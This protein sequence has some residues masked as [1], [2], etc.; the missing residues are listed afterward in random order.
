MTRKEHEKRKK[1]NI[2][3]AK[4][5]LRGAEATLDELR[6]LAKEL[7]E[8]T[9]F[10]YAWKIIARA[11]RR[12]EVERDRDLNL[13]LAQQQAVSTY[14]DP[15]LPADQKLDRAFEILEK[16]DNLRATTNQETL[17][18]AGAIYK[19][20][21]EL[22][23]HK[24]HLERSLAFYLRGHAQGVETGDNGYTGI[25]A[26][27]ILDLLAEQEEKDAAEAYTVSE[28]APKRRAE[29][30]HIREEI[31]DKLTKKAAQPGNDWLLQ[32]WWFL[33]T[34]AEAHFGMRHYDEARVW[35]R[36]AAALADVADWERESTVRQLVRLA[37]LRQKNGSDV[38]GKA[39]E[40]PAWDTLREFLKL[41]YQELPSAAVEAALKTAFRG[42]VGLALSGGGFRASLYHIGVLARLAELDVLRHVEVL[43]CVSGGSIIG[44][45]YYLEVRNLLQTVQEGDIK[46]EHYIKI[47]QKIEK[48]FL[49]GVQTNIRTRV[50][51]E[52][53]TNVK[54][55]FF[56]NYSRTMRVGELYEKQ[57]YSRIKD[58]PDKEKNEPR[59]LNELTVQPLGD[60]DF[61]PKYDNWRRWAK[62]PILV[63]NAT[64][65]NTGHN[66][67]FTATWM[68]EPPSAIDTDVDGNYRLRRMY[69][70]DAPGDYPNCRLG[71]AVAASS[72]VP[73]LFEPLA[74]PNLYENPK[75]KE[76][77]TVR[78]VD[79]GVHDNQGTASLLEQG[80]SVLL[81]SD[82]SGQ[83]NSE[84]DPGSGTLEVVMRS[85]SVL[86]ARVR[87]A[88]Y[89]ELAARRRSA[90]LE[91]LMF[92][93]LKMDLGVDPIDW[94]SCSDPFAAS[95]DARPLDLQ[96]PLARYGLNKERQRRLAAIRTDL[97]SFSDAEA[98]ALMA[99]GYFMTDYCFPRNI[100]G[101]RPPNGPRT[102]WSFLKAEKLMKEDESKSAF[103]AVLQAACNLFFKIWILS[104]PLKIVA[105][106]L[107]VVAIALLIWFRSYWWPI[108]VFTLTMGA[109]ATIAATLVGIKLLGST[110]M[111][112]VRYRKTAQEFAIG[113]GMSVLGF[114][115]ARLH[116]H[117]FDKWYLRFGRSDRTLR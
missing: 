59:W 46:R 34:V 116:L 53:W 35:L 27:F 86:Q 12:P 10:G 106:A 92:I 68:G 69:Y 87:Q 57:I 91:G 6:K 16:A 33:C 93:H 77:I 62:V 117:V 60:T 97:D 32:Q 4:E 44:A 13:P 78:L 113:L 107:G 84:D 73:G 99:S 11:R 71:Y 74:L 61:N 100:S 24:Q 102:E 38:D 52:W 42:K 25:N 98:Y 112:L 88:Q 22:D 70:P 48:D 94:I 109:V 49:A 103:A 17:G 115:V 83:M 18:I 66:W 89:R 90:L 96:G 56:S 80:C 110:M 26:A 108:Q 75:T 21:W 47:V 9:A 23:W 95:E 2:A 114:G 31:A 28:T 111:K 36:R 65:L 58:R 45:H 82:A 81:V 85:N 14:K 7:K 39:E 55:I 105:A 50:A 15:D 51:A 72:C 20:R 79:G 101:F 63:L 30:Q 76:K 54:M 29:A 1:E 64:S 3:R 41:L 104:R 43:S 67:Q 40:S 8:D 19:R 5:I 37:Q